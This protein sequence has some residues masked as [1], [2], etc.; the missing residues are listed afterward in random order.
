MCSSDLFQIGKNPIPS[1]IME[2]GEGGTEKLAVIHRGTWNW[3][4]GPKVRAPF[5]EGFYDPCRAVIETRPD[6]EDLDFGEVSV[7]AAL[8][9][10]M[11]NRKPRRF[12]RLF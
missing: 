1:L 3:N 5:L 12:L 4:M 6:A 11:R 9:P 10:D 2:A 8:S 7:R